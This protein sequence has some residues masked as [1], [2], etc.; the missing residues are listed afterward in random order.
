[1]SEVLARIKQQ[2]NRAREL[3]SEAQRILKGE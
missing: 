2:I 3:I 1:M